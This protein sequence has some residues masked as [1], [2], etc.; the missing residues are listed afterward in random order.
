MT[1]SKNNSSGS[2]TATAAPGT[3]SDTAPHHVGTDTLGK[4]PDNVAKG[5]FGRAK[6]AM[7][8]LEDIGADLDVQSMADDAATF[9]RRNPAVSLAAAAGLGAVIGA[10]VAKR[11]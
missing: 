4:G 1:V 10:M 7:P 3:T 11:L 5:P 2:K 9:V 8:S 6:E